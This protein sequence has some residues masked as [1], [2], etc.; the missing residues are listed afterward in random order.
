MANRALGEKKQLSK[1]STMA[2]LTK[3]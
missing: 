2:F 1:S 3:S